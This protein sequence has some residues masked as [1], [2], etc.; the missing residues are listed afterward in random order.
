MGAGATVARARRP[1]K[2]LYLLTAVQSSV[3]LCVRV[4]INTIDEVQA[5]RLNPLVWQ[6]RRIRQSGLH[7]HRLTQPRQLANGDQVIGLFVRV[8][9]GGRPYLFGQYRGFAL[10]HQN[11]DRAIRDLH[12]GTPGRTPPGS[13]SDSSDEDPR[14]VVFDSWEPAPEL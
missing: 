8:N 12:P 5:H 3:D 4:I 13:E 14:N 11:I 6:V 7:L 9:T 1:E 2:I 10:T